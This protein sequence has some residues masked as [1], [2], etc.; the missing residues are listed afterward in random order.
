[1]PG[2]NGFMQK[3]SLI[4]SS[5]ILIVVGLLTWFSYKILCAKKPVLFITQ[6]PVRRDIT[7]AMH[8]EGIVEIDQTIKICSLINA[9][10]KKIFVHEGDFVHKN[11]VLAELENYKGGDTELRIARAHLEHAQAQLTTIEHKLKREKELLRMGALAQ[12]T[13]EEITE[14]YACALADVAAKRACYEK[15]TFLFQQTTLRAPSNGTI[16][17]VNVEPGETVNAEAMP[18][19]ALFT[20]A[21]NITK[22]KATIYIDEAKIANIKKGMKTEIT[23]D[24]YPHKQPWVSTIETISFCKWSPPSGSSQQT[25][26]YKAELFIDN[27]D[28]LLR[29][30]MNIHARTILAHASQALSLPGLVFQINQ[31]LLE[32]IAHKL[33]YQFIPLSPLVKEELK[34]TSQHPIKTVWV[35]TK[36]TFIEKAVE[37]G[38]TDNTY[39]EILSGINETDEIISDDMAAS[40]ELEKIAKRVAG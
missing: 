4:F 36:N 2:R 5:L 31:K 11:E 32:V 26:G 25:P 37:I 7:H 22:M 28:N 24:T 38:V 34:K 16:V 40:D 15:E 14:R 17:S 6:K 9:K 23:V 12:E 1:M 39:F 18:P 19:K 21:H 20:F 35:H 10:I 8:A 30:D 27:S 33:K 13:F 3:K 29:P